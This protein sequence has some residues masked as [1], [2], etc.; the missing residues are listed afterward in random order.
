MFIWFND[1]REKS[2]YEK[3]QFLSN[4]QLWMSSILDVTVINKN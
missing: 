1:E 3:E 2:N 4:S